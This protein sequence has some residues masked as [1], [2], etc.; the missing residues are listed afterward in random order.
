MDLQKLFRPASL[1]ALL[2]LLLTA[3]CAAGCV[4]PEPAPPGPAAVVEAIHQAWV[5]GEVD[6]IHPRVDYRF[7]LAE[8]I[9]PLWD[10][11]D[12][13]DQ[14]RTV[15]LVS[16]M[17]VETLERVWNAYVA[18]RAL[19][20]T[21]RHVPSER[22]DEPVAWVTVKAVPAASG[23]KPFA[24]EYRLHRLGGAWK[25]TQREYRVDFARSDTTTFF[26][27][28]IKRLAAEYGRPP[29]LAEVNANLPSLRQRMRQ[30]TFKVPELPGMKKG[31]PRVKKSDLEGSPS[32]PRQEPSDETEEGASPPQQDKTTP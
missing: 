10:A 20:I 28:V 17:F 32:Q 23:D 3:G 31:G 30:R 21:E 9:G 8:T 2:A 6:A 5:S 16:G 29:T 27:R 19:V 12:P 7:R 24:F 18:G 4:D 11:S 15:E 1:R 25:V 26:P 14:A 13:S 22:S